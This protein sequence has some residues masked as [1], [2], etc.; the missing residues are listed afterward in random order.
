MKYAP[1][2]AEGDSCSY[3]IIDQTKELIQKYD[4]ITKG[5]KNGAPVYVELDVIDMGKTDEGFAADYEGVYS[6][7]KIK[8]NH[9]LLIGSIPI[10]QTRKGKKRSLFL[11]TLLKTIITNKPNIFS[12]SH[13]ITILVQTSMFSIVCR[14]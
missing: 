3:W 4:E 6:V 1:L 5:S 7:T 12:Q 10:L 14:T 13:L 11:L 9:Q 8:K 2:R